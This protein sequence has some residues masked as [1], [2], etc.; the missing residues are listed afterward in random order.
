VEETTEREADRTVLV[1]T[2]AKTAANGALRWVYPFLP[3][4]ASGIGVPLGTMSTAAG[5]AEL[6]GLSSAVAGPDL[7]RGRERRWLAGGMALVAAGCAIAPLGGTVAVFALGFALVT[8]GVAVFTTAGHTWIGL[9]VPF[10][11]RARSIGIYETS[12]A[13]G[14]LLAAPVCAALIAW[15][16]WWAP[17][18]ALALV[19]AVVAVWVGRVTPPDVLRPRSAHGRLV[20][21]LH[22]WAVLVTSWALAV[23]SM[24]VFVSYGAWLQDAFG[25]PVGLVGV[26]SVLAALL[27]LGASILTASRSDR[28]GKHRAVQLGV[29]VMVV[30]VVA[31][32][33]SGS[34]A[35]V[36]VPAFMLFLGGFEFA[37][38]SNLALVTE[39]AVETRGAAVGLDHALGTVARA[40][41]VATGGIAFEAWGMGGVAVISGAAAVVGLGA[42]TGARVLANRRK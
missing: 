25:F 11:R 41:G 39:A 38:V 16:G 4:I 1:L 40:V 26:V 17:F 22:G 36:G 10:A 13:V 20:L 19:N 23:G 33:A 21:P 27:E 28:W 24:V 9:R 5:I 35:Y 12:W 31:L 3:N 18:A 29:L 6:A 14:L 42:A 34:A 8:T 2:G 37:F 15:V 32:P 30:G 7:D